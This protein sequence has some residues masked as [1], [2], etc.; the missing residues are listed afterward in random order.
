MWTCEQV[1]VH[2]D[3]P[4]ALCGELRVK[5]RVSRFGG[6]SCCPPPPAVPGARWV[7]LSPLGASASSAHPFTSARPAW[8]QL[9]PSQL[10]RA[11]GVT[12]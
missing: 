12:P 9:G 6:T 5:P 4:G 3:T 8:E 10:G 1:P 7:L 11:E 2:R